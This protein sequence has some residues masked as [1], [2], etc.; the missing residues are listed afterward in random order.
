MNN[1][2]MHSMND[3][4]SNFFLLADLKIKLKWI[5]S[6]TIQPNLMKQTM[7]DNIAFNHF[8]DLFQSPYPIPKAKN[9]IKRFLNLVFV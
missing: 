8:L 3:F 1:Q 7:T 5:A 9:E 6:N 4:D 2:V